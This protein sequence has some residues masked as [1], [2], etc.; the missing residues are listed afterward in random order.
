M[1]GS[2]DG[3]QAANESNDLLKQQI[4]DQKKEEQE[5]LH[6]MYSDELVSLK[7]SGVATYQSGGST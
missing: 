6:S 5:K 4:A 1:G 3:S 2:S 7:S